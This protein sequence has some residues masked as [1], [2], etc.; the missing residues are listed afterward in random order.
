MTG[1]NAYLILKYY[2]SKECKLEKGEGF[3][4]SSVINWPEPEQGVFAGC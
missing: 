1:P 4:I 2:R 3:S